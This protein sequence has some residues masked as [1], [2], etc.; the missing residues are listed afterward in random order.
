MVGDD[1]DQK[2]G[3]CYSFT[4]FCTMTK[5]DCQHHA[6]VGSEGEHWQKITCLVPP[7]CNYLSC[8]ATQHTALEEPVEITEA[9][10]VV[11][12][13]R[14]PQ[15]DLKSWSWIFQ[16]WFKL[17]KVFNFS[18]PRPGSCWSHLLQRT[19]RFLLVIKRCH[20]TWSLPHVEKR[21]FVL[22]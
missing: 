6:P 20:Q 19:A 2:H 3:C 13:M 17:G 9:Q 1:R 21:D 18:R 14:L 22:F 16:V 5:W 7:Y 15:T 11:D 8:L 12:K 10:V 4:G